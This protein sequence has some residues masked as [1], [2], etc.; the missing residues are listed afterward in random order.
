MNRDK[1]KMTER[2]TLVNDSTRSLLDHSIPSSCVKLILQ[3]RAVVK[4]V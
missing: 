1:L 3:E 4:F 2:T